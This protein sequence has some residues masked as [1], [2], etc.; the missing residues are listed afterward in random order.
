MYQW[1]FYLTHICVTRTKRVN[2]MV[3]ED[4]LINFGP[5]FGVFPTQIWWVT[6]RLFF[7]HHICR[8]SRIILKK[9]RFCVSGFLLEYVRYSFQS[10]LWQSHTHQ[11]IHITMVVAIWWIRRSTWRSVC[12]DWCYCGITV[13]WGSF[14]GFTP[15]AAIDEAITF[16]RYQFT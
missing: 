5:C 10:S 2:Q 8:I 14:L 3:S 9:N 1:Y 15:I 11:N 12:I 6:K 16:V 7:A 13:L 4:F